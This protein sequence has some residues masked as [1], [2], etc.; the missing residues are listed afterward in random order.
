[1]KTEYEVK[2]LEI[3]HNKMVEKLERLGAIKKI[4]ALQEG[5]IYD[6]IPKNDHQW[7]RLRTNGEKN[8]LTLKSLQAKTIDG[9]KEIEIEVSDFYE[10]HKL[11]ENIG[12][13]NKGFQQNKR[14]QYILDGV[15]IDLDHWPLIPEYM[16]IEGD[17]EESVDK[18]LELLDVD[19]EK[20]VTLDVTSIY[21]HYGFEEP[22]NLSFDMEENNEKF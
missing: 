14:V 21:K 10:T 12:F 8:T 6:V 11:L 9:M 3:D 7:L 17:S 4:D 22:D 16:E 13:H 20:I 15:E 2:V 1:M 19:K 18:M 5:Y